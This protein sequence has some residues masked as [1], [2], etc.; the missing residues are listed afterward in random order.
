M[1][2]KTRI[3]TFLDQNGERILV[4]ASALMAAFFITFLMVLADATTA[5][6]SENPEISCKGRNLIEV[7]GAEDPAKLAAITGAAEK[8][9]NGNSVFWKIK[10]A[11]IE[12]SYLLGTMHLADSRIAS[13]D[14]AKGEAFNKAQT[15]IVENI[16]ALDSAEAS[17]AIIQY[18]EMT[19]Y[20]D[21]T[22]LADRLDP[23][24]L[25]KLQ[26]TA[27]ARGIP[28]S[29]ALVMQPWLVAASLSLP[30]CE[31]AAKQQGAEVLDGLIGTRAKAEGKELVGLETI[32]EQFSAM[33]NMPEEFHLMALKE[34]LDLGGVAEDVIETMK[35]LYLEGRIGMIEPLTKSVAPQT[36]GSKDYA[37][38]NTRLITDRNKVMAERSLAYME[39]G[40]AFMAV[41]ALHLPGELGL[42]ELL[43]REGYS[44]S[45]VE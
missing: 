33:A 38:F 34:T 4:A 24:T 17:V 3:T 14:G 39:K 28:Y 25:A 40:N 9:L 45:A 30:A 36:A 20:T 23:E 42:V 43:R 15:V 44:L 32:G 11:G 2:K 41:G 27:E 8:T 21:G 37:E 16:E 18:K 13:L 12:P 22:T 6:A 35:L 1:M 26:K 19:L 10:K 29:S 7:Y 5:K 31:M